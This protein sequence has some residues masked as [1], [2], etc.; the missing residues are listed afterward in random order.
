MNASRFEAH[1]RR[2]SNASRV[3]DA[4]LVVVFGWLALSSDAPEWI[5]LWIACGVLC[6]LTAIFGPIEKLF[7][8]LRARFLKSGV[9]AQPVLANDNAPISR[10]QRRAMERGKAKH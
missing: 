1:V 5:A 7:A 10:Q 6:L 4:V 2:V 3:M 9:K 8:I